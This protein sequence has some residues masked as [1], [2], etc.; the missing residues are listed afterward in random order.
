VHC[1]AAGAEAQA[2]NVIVQPIEPR[3][4]KRGEREVGNAPAIDGMQFIWRNARIEPIENIIST[5]AD[6]V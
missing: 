5:S 4:G 2:G 6:A 3:V 1:S